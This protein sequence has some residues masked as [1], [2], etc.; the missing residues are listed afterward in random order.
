MKLKWK[1]FVVPMALLPSILLAQAPASNSIQTQREAMHKLAFLEGKWSGPVTVVRGP[2]E[3]LHLTQ[4]EQIEYKLDGLV[5]LIEGSSTTAHGETPFRALA[6]IAYDD[7]SHAY[8]I[9]AYNDGHYIDTE[10]TTADKGFSWNFDAGPAHV[11]N[12]MHLTNKGE[13]NEVT[14]VSF[15]SGPAHRSVEMLLQRQP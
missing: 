1:F 8:R 11:V 10:L 14:D 3:P 5:L 6:T 4:T 15:G 12:T 2:G 13:W 7:G 9:R